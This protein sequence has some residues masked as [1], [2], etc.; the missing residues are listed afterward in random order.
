MTFVTADP[1]ASSLAQRTSLSKEYPLSTLSQVSPMSSRKAQNEVTQ[2]DLKW[3]GGRDIQ[4]ALLVQLEGREV[5]VSAHN[6]ASPRPR[7]ANSASELLSVIPRGRLCSIYASVESFHDPLLLPAEKP[8]S[9]RTSWDFVLDIDSSEGIEEARRCT[10]SIVGLLS[11]YGLQCVRVKFSGRRGFHIIVDGEAFDCFSTRE[12]FLRAYPTVPSQVARFVIAA[13]RPSDR[14]GI[15]VDTSMYAP[16]HLIRIAY[17]L[18]HKTGLA[19]LPVEPS[20]L[21]QFN[22][23]AMKP[24]NDIDVD[25]HWLQAKAKPMEAST[26]LDYVIK[27]LQRTQS[28]RVGMRVLNRSRIVGPRRSARNPPCVEALSKEGFSKRLEG[29][30]NRVLYAVLSG[31]RRLNFAITP[32]ELEELN[33]RSERP[34]PEREL[35][36]Q[37]RYQLSRPRP[38]RFHCNIMQTAGLCPQQRCPIGRFTVGKEAEKN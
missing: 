1:E 29:H 23:E 17:S 5:W 9:L 2:P 37:I 34:L 15:E 27:W 35:R 3:Y 7:V 31:I 10:K 6:Y 38:Y 11:E 20:S 36:Y 33:F 25:W 24:R 19:S 12:E 26:L 16:R 18:H 22:I 28:N 32:E 8:D 30:R 21:D 4:D 13:L 14:R